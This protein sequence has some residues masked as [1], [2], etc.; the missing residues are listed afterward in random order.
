MPAI[1]TFVIQFCP[2]MLR[3]L[4]VPGHPRQVLCRQPQD[5]FC[6]RHLIRLLMLV[7]AVLF[8][9]DSPEDRPRD[10]TCWVGQRFLELR[11]DMFSFRHQYLNL[12]QC[13]WN[14][15]SGSLFRFP[16]ETTSSATRHVL[17]ILVLF[18]LHARRPVIGHSSDSER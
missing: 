1:A 13:S 8:S 10:S 2:L 18:Q 7:N 12:R 4:K 16:Q 3:G 11:P 15:E 14:W 17:M 5:R 6:Q 9:L